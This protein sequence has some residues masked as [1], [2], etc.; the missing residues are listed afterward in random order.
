MK[1]LL[2][3]FLGATILLAC[4]DGPVEPPLE[5][6]VFG[7]VEFWSGDFMPVTDP[8]APSGSVEPVERTL[9][10]FAGAAFDDVVVDPQRGSG[11][12]LDVHTRLID[13][14]RSHAD[15]SYRIALPAGA[16]SVFVREFDRYYASTSN[17]THI[18]GVRVDSGE[19]VEHVVKIT[20][21]ATF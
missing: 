6:G 5:Q 11:F 14:A 12:Y 7:T 9:Y 15:G 20:Y 3:V 2:S 17:G 13:S 1:R 16:Y 21:K 19:A 4:S 18:G 10:V 8:D